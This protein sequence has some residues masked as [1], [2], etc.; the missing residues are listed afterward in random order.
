VKYEEPIQRAAYTLAQKLRCEPWYH[1]TTYVWTRAF[2]CFIKVYANYRKG[3]RVPKAIPT[4]WH[5]FR[6]VVVRVTDR[7]RCPFGSVKK[8][9]G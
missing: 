6:V 3:G 5:G 8:R 7:D 2:G 4:D 1:R 9:G